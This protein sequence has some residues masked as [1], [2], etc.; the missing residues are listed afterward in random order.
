M[1]N[2]PTT[3]DTNSQLHPKHSQQHIFDMFLCRRVNVSRDDINKVQSFCQA[4]QQ[5][6]DRYGSRD[7]SR[8]DTGR[9]RFLNGFIGKIGEVGAAKIF[10]G[11]VDFRVWATGQRGIDQFEP[12]IE[13]TST[14]YNLHVKTCHMK[15]T[16]RSQRGVVPTETASW[17]IDV[18]DPLMKNPS[19][20]DRIILMFAS[21]HGDVHYLGWIDA[22]AALPFWKPCL[23]PTLSHKRAI[24]IHD[25]W[26]HIEQ[27]TI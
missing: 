21:D 19:D 8:G 20:H 12:D 14:S 7:R 23:S 4:I 9:H 2:A 25:I 13:T 22:K 17:T 11:K 1:S 10:G 15:H 27:T 5:K 6:Q 24:Y 3:N 18:S 16:M 26:K